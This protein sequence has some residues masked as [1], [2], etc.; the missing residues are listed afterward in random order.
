MSGCKEEANLMFARGLLSRQVANIGARVDK[1]IR[2]AVDVMYVLILLKLVRGTPILTFRK[3]RVGFA[4]VGRLGCSDAL[5]R[6]LLHLSF[7][8]RVSLCTSLDFG[9]E[10]CV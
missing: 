7:G 5:Q 1:R 6:V 3:S 4:S 2:A 9:M 10:P 8:A